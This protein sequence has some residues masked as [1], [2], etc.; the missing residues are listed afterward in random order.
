MFSW[1][2]GFGSSLEGQ[3]VS[4]EPLSETWRRW[5]LI[6]QLKEWRGTEMEVIVCGLLEVLEHEHKWKLWQLYELRSRN[7]LGVE[8]DDLFDEDDEKLFK[9]EK[10]NA[11]KMVKEVIV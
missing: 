8:E 10:I 5:E 7:G 6:R 2:A 3:V 4:Y 1:R 9:K 11:L